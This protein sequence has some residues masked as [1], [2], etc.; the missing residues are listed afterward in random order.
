MT[1]NGKKI[2]CVA[3]ASALCL[4][5]GFSAVLPPLTASADSY[6]PYL[7]SYISGLG[8]QPTMSAV[9]YEVDSDPTQASSFWQYRTNLDGYADSNSNY[10]YA[11]TYGTFE[12][13][14]S[15]A[16]A[17]SYKTLDLNY[18]QGYY[19][20]LTLESVSFSSCMPSSPRF[21][22]SSQW[23]CWQ[24]LGL[25]VNLVV[26]DVAYVPSFEEVNAEFRIYAY[27]RGENADS[28]T[29]YLRSYVYPCTGRVLAGRVMLVN[30]LPD[31]AT[32]LADNPEV[33]YVSHD[34]GGPAGFMG[35]ITFSLTTDLDGL[36]E[37]HI[38]DTGMNNAIMA[39]NNYQSAEVDYMEQF[40]VVNN[41]T[42][43]DIDPLSSVWNVV[44]GFFSSELFPGFKIGDLLAI[45]IGS[46]LLGLFL[47]IF[48]GG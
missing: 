43:Y 25:R 7:N 21:L 12:V 13:E 15:I 20:D 33:L 16:Y 41:V 24:S 19:G 14:A 39:Y 36:N 3:L 1:N 6:A 45:A 28:N 38:N 31:L 2:A 30:P 27:A 34:D 46:L 4:G 18:Y 26:E 5:V 40:A 9:L 10:T 35:S 48:L 8:V 23:L 17:G 32:F 37:I 47:K 42:R 44:D 29:P 11:D 22:H